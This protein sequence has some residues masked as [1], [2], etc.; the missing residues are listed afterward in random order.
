MAY[1]PLPNPPS[2][3]LDPSIS[4]NMSVDISTALD[5]NITLPRLA[6]EMLPAIEM[7]DL[8]EPDG[9]A[10]M[11]FTSPSISNIP[12]IDQLLDEEC[13]SGIH[14]DLTI[15]T[16]T[17]EAQAGME[18]YDDEFE[19]LESAGCHIPELLEYEHSCFSLIPFDDTVSDLQPFPST[20]SLHYGHL[21]GNSDSKPVESH[22]ELNPA[23]ETS[24]GGIAL[25]LNPEIDEVLYM[26]SLRSGRSLTSSHNVSQPAAESVSFASHISLGTH[27]SEVG[28]ACIFSPRP[29][30]ESLVLTRAQSQRRYAGLAIPR[31]H[32]PGISSSS[33]SPTSP[34]PTSSR[35]QNVSNGPS[36]GSNTS[37]SS[38]ARHI[39]TRFST[40]QASSPLPQRSSKFFLPNPKRLSFTTKSK[41]L[42]LSSGKKEK[43]LSAPARIVSPAVASPEYPVIASPSPLSSNLTFD[44]SAYACMKV[45]YYAHSSILQPTVGDVVNSPDTQQTLSPQTMGYPRYELHRVRC[46]TPGQRFSTFD[47]LDRDIPQSGSVRFPLIVPLPSPTGDK[48][49]VP[50]QQP[51]LPQSQIIRPNSWFGSPHLPLPNPYSPQPGNG[52]EQNWQLVRELPERVTLEERLTIE[53][54]NAMDTRDRHMDG[55]WAG[56]ARSMSTSGYHT[57]KSGSKSISLVEGRSAYPGIGPIMD[58][59]ATSM[60]AAM[61]FGYRRRNAMLESNSSPG[62]TEAGLQVP[63]QPSRTRRRSSLLGLGLG[64]G[65]AKR[66]SSRSLS[67]KGSLQS[68]TPVQLPPHVSP[69][70]NE[71]HRGNL[72]P[73]DVRNSQNRRTYRLG[74]SLRRPSATKSNTETSGQHQGLKPPVLP[75][76]PMHTVG[77]HLDISDSF[78]SWEK[79]G[80]DER[81]MGKEPG[82]SPSTRRSFGRIWEKL[83]KMPKIVG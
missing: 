71:E 79:V 59:R 49:T 22:D 53:V 55:N 56:R 36:Q 60:G 5:A 75:Q 43:R 72:S 57:G 62:V 29:P 61:E 7:T 38:K 9:P 74:L 67:N 35:S 32:L 82:S 65:S 37:K 39:W 31:D 70:V 77:P 40:P 69:Q 80:S 66:Q 44:T 45:P 2:T 8:L 30:L 20:A 26:S 23:V 3:V 1:P 13:P 12:D 78:P 25:E 14:Q 18:V 6:E 54:L 15:N 42:L 76:N 64:L 11:R 68:P 34:V 58:R 4:L 47:G 48:L 19:S 73:E 63:E 24:E 41:S 27:L 10:V 21:R 52:P 51:T 17:E 33:S 28:E 83:K 16:E 50:D 81:P 46:R